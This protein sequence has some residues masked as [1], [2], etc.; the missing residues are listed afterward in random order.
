[1]RRELAPFVNASN[2]RIDGPDVVLDAEAGQ[3]LAMTFHELV[4]NAAKFGAISVESG[5]V[6]VHWNLIRN[7]QAESCLYIQWEESGGPPVV[8]PARSGYGTSVMRELV[9]YELGGTVDLRLPP[10]GVRCKLRIPGHWLNDAA[11]L[12]NIKLATAQ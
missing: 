10:H 4:T 2:S 7:G 12:E 3:T 5:R 6:S 1:V 11:V 8:P 9:P